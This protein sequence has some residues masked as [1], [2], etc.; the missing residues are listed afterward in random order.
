MQG[1]HLPLF[2]PFFVYLVWTPF[3]A[4]QGMRPVKVCT[5]LQPQVTFQCPRHAILLVLESLCHGQPVRG[6][7]APL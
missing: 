5:G 6:E 1:S 2:H 7:V 4:L 3:P